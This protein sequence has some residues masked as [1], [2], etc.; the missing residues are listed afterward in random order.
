MQKL[1]KWVFIA[2]ALALVLTSIFS[3]GYHQFDEHFQI[4]EFAG[5]KLN[6]TTSANLP[7]EYFEQMR[8]AIQPAIVVCLYN[9]TGLF[10]LNNPFTVAFILRLM[11]ATLA[12]LGML[13]LYKV[14]YKSI[15]TYTLKKLFLFLSFLLWFIV[16][17]GVRFSSENW[18]GT[19]FIIAF[20][21]FFLAKKQNPLFF[22][23][24]GLLL[25]LSFIFRY[26]AGFLVAGF[27]GWLLFIK[28]EKILNISIL[29]A[30]VAVV[31]LLGVLIDRWF[32]GEWT[33]TAWHYFEQNV[34]Q[35]KAATFGVSPWWK[36]IEQFTL[37]AI[38]PFSV[39]FVLAFIPFLVFRIKSP[40]AWSII[41]F[42]AVH[43]I[44]GHKE[45]RFLFPIVY[46][47][48]I[49]LITGIELIEEKY[50]SKFSS[51]RYF[52]IFLSV[53]YTIYLVLLLI[54]CFKPADNHISLY[55]TIYNNYNTPTTLHYISEN[56]YFR[57]ANINFYKRESLQI[58]QVASLS[59][60]ESIP[61]GKNLIVFTNKDKPAAMSGNCK[62]I[63]S[64]YPDWAFALNF[65]NW[66]SRTKAW[67]V[68]ELEGN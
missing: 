30:G 53:F 36:Y 10:G 6:L 54:V 40:I 55:R 64:S 42:L 2:S 47:L 3:L 1:E 60:V 58:K 35:N 66:I 65:G 37:Q 18:A 57:V 20:S 32:Y 21:L 14:Y 7:W 49:I 9:F 29:L 27:V 62:L 22:F 28:R 8:P 24:I 23:Y 43:F 31:T 44:I 19:F 26:Q 68:Y 56:P 12:F 34:I 15:S 16:Y 45:L 41:P 25:G 50:I 63:Y 61:N 48:P 13:L 52:R 33:F 46:F 67:Y 38:P 4:L 51:Q 11:S 5:L 17:N 59:E 39:L